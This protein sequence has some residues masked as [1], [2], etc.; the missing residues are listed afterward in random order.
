M[1]YNPAVKLIDNLGAPQGVKFADGKPRVSTMPYLYDI[2]EGNVA[3]HEIRRAIGYN[4]GTASSLTSINGSVVIG[5]NA[6][7]HISGTG[8]LPGPFHVL[9]KAALG[10]TGTF[11]PGNVTGIPAGFVLDQA[12]DDDA[13]AAGASPPHYPGRAAD[14]GGPHHRRHYPHRRRRLLLRRSRSRR[15]GLLRLLCLC[16]CR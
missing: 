1:T 7:L 14:G 2:A 8:T 12:Y 13:N 16:L 4:A 6:S 9:V 5:A 3:N 15:R 11:A 10:I